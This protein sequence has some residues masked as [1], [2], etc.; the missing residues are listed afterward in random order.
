MPTL[1]RGVGMIRVGLVCGAA[2]VLA[3]AAE[4]QLPP[5]TPLALSTTPGRIVYVDTRR[6][7][8]SEYH[9][10]VRVTGTRGESSSDRPLFLSTHSFTF[11]APEGRAFFP[12]RPP[13]RPA[14]STPAS[15][16]TSPRNRRRPATWCFAFRSTCPPGPSKSR[17]KNER[18]MARA[19]APRPCREDR[20]GGDGAEPRWVSGSVC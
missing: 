4:A 19:T 5:S 20:V 15:R 8:T 9:F 6:V 2:L 11:V 10:A 3:A 1:S 7:R 17:S 14:S 12:L 18:E 16:G 13:R